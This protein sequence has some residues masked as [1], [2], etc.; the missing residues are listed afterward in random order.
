M[1]KTQADWIAEYVKRNALWLHDGNPKRPHAELTSGKHSNG[2]F[3]SSFIIQ[4]ASLV[5]QAAEDLL[6]KLFDEGIEPDH[7][8]RF[9]GSAYGVITLPHELACQTAKLCAFTEAVGDGPMMLRR[10]SEVSAGHR[11]VVCDDVVSTGGTT[12]EV[13]A[14]LERKG[15]EVLPRILCFVNR[16]GMT[17]LDDRRIIALVDKPMSMWE[18]S[19]CPL[20]AEGSVALRPKKEHWATLN[21]QY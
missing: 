21:A 2:F 19:E 15:A 14:D 13:I 17:H 7:Y 10:F 16:S 20:C 5:A 12:R 8:D 9:V 11:I 6:V 1:T 3:N 18:P 4:D